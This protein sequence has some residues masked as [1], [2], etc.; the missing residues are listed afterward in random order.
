[1]LFPIATDLVKLKGIDL[2]CVAVTVTIWN[3]RTLHGDLLT[4]TVT[5]FPGESER[6]DGG[7][8]DDVERQPNRSVPAILKLFKYS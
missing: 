3:T 7:A 4:V 6:N 1:M 2:L 5:V 8:G